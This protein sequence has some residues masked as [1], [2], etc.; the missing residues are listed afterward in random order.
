MG[1]RWNNTA[2]ILKFRQP[3]SHRQEKRWEQQG[4][5]ELLPVEQD[6]VKRLLPRSNR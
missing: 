4:L 5:R 1:E 3:H 6:G 2:L